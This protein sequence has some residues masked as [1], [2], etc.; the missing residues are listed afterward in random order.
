MKAPGAVV[1]VSNMCWSEQIEPLGRQIPV[2]SR[3]DL[4]RAA[5]ARVYGSPLILIADRSLLHQLSPSES[6][7]LRSLAHTGEIRLVPYADPVILDLARDQGLQVVSRDHFLDLRRAHP[8]IPGASE[9]FLTC[10]TRDGV[11]GFETTGVCE[12]AEQVKSR[13]EEHKQLNWENRI[14]LDNRAHRRVLRSHWR[15]V[16]ATCYQAMLWPDRLRLWPAM[17]DDGTVSCPSCGSRAEQAGPRGVTRVIV[18]SNHEDDG[19]ILR[20][21]MSGDTALVIGRGGVTN[22]V[23]LA[24]PDLPYPTSTGKV[25]R[26]HLFLRMTA[27]GTNTHISAVDLES[28][29]GT[30][31]VR[32]GAD[33]RNMPPG[34]ESIIGERDFLI[35]GRRVRL[36]IS[37]LRFPTEISEPTRGNGGD[38]ITEIDN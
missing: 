3:I 37:G 38:F 19:E 7:T 30:E 29:N 5:W 1:D 23:D 11:L 15:C 6:R 35:L 14:D 25:S 34:V 13:A 18:V 33:S 8:W 20:F 36:R 27:K 32:D 21:P 2:L 17:D 26:R 12:V 16:A 9:R 24:A 10:A 31:I 28:T 22:G 4:L